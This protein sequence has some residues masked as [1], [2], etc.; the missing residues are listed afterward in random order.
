MK[1]S[2]LVLT[3]L[4]MARLFNHQSEGMIRMPERYLNQNHNTPQSK[5]ATMTSKAWK[6]RKVKLRMTRE[7]RRSNRV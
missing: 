4:L 6:K 1:K 2:K 5:P 7:S 3:A